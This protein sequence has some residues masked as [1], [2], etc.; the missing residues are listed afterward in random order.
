M[1][2]FCTKCGNEI[3]AD[4]KFCNKCGHPVEKSISQNNNHSAQ[5]NAI[6]KGTNRS[7]QNRVSPLALNKSAGF[8]N[9]VIALIAAV[10][11]IG[12]IGY[13]LFGR[14]PSDSPD[15]VVKTFAT[16]VCDRLNGKNPDMT[17]YNAL[18]KNP[19]LRERLSEEMFD[20][21]ILVPK[22][23]RGEIAYLLGKNESVQ[24]DDK[25]LRFVGIINKNSKNIYG[26]I[27]LAIRKIDGKY[28]IV[29]AGFSDD[30]S[31]KNRDYY[32]EP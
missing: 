27:V 9:M 8:N 13:F 21:N 10:V 11:I 28:Y 23:N 31:T 29:N 20:W 22:Q 30:P 4:S 32:K 16:T 3:K 26:C 7:A 6:P 12:G 24:K 5:D 15:M 17:A 2:Q 19:S 1:A 25:Y 14:S 18:W